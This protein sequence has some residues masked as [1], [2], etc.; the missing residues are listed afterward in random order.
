M[1]GGDEHR[2][3]GVR[4]ECVRD[5]AEEGACYRAAPALAAAAAA[6]AAVVVYSS[7]IDEVLGLATRVIVVHDGQVRDAPL[8]RTSVGRAML[9]VVS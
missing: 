6:G 4:G 7:D 9:G 3:L 8:D 1:L 2:P 5:A